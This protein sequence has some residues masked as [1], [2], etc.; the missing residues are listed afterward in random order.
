MAAAEPDDLLA[1]ARARAAEELGVSL[2]N[3]TTLVFYAPGSP[4]EGRSFAVGKFRAADGNALLIAIDADTGE[5]L[6][7]EEYAELKSLERGGRDKFTSTARQQTELTEQQLYGVLLRTPDYS[8]AIDRVKAAHPDLEWRERYPVSSDLDALR[9]TR[10]ELMLAKA[11]LNEA[12]IAPFVAAAR[13]EGITDLTP[14][15]LAPMVY[16]RAPG[17]VIES[18]AKRADV[19]EIRATG[20]YL[21]SMSSAYPT[22]RGD[23]TW[24]QAWRGSG[25]RI[26]IVEYRRVDWTRTGMP[27]TSRRQELYVGGSY[28]NLTCNAGTPGALPSEHYTRVVAIAASNDDVGTSR[29][30]ATAATVVASSANTNNDDTQDADR[31]VIKAV[32]CAVLNGNADMISTSLTQNFDKPLGEAY[33]DHLVYEHGIFT[34]SAA[35][36]NPTDSTSQ[37]PSNEQTQS[38]ASGWNVLAIGGIDDKGDG[39]LANDTLWYRADLSEPAFCWRSPPAEAGELND[40]IKPEI[41]APAKDVI[42]ANYSTASSGTSYATPMAAGVAAIMMSLD[43]TII[44]KPEAVRAGIMAASA[45]KRTPVPGGGTS[46]AVE[47]VGSLN[48]RWT[49]IL[50][51]G[52]DPTDGSSNRGNLNVFTM[53][54]V[55]DAFTGCFRAPADRTVSF[56]GVAGRSMRFVMVWNSHTASHAAHTNTFDTRYGDLDLEIRNPGGSIIGFSRSAASNVEYDD[57]SASTTG[58][59]QAK[60]HVF[61]WDCRVA[62]E[63]VGWAW[64]SHDF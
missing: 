44:A 54:G 17:P 51:N 41:S 40:R 60:I 1:R 59:Y 62:S 46:E 20:P 11:A 14:L 7:A 43:P 10:H 42:A 16:V 50:V 24:D 22:V 45:V 29:G 18:L 61:E 32:E 55:Y 8:P 12:A 9:T 39:A 57:F 30:I 13:Q 2:A 31:R 33:F 23:W 28:P 48:A 6:T 49:G 3:V 21:E 25:I 34:V 56:T 53:N 47:G 4:L 52:S 64:L 58:T 27:G 37:C 63:E 26:G 35:G 36:N 15:Q 5:T 38:P 19:V